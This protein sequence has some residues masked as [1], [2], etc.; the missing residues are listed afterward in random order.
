MANLLPVPVGAASA[1]APVRAWC[2]GRIRV[3][4]WSP[5][6][7]HAWYVGSHIAMVP[8]CLR[9]GDGGCSHQLLT[10]ATHGRPSQWSTLASDRGY[11]LCGL[12]RARARYEGCTF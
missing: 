9:F 7:L 3:C 1:L 2:G 8:R 5:A 6:L 11:I 10:P 4:T 12:S